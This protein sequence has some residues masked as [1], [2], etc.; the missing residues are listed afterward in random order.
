MQARPLGH[1]ENHGGGTECG[2]AVSLSQAGNLRTGDT[3]PIKCLSVGKTNKRKFISYLLNQVVNE[4]FP[5]WFPKI[6]NDV[7]TTNS[8]NSFPLH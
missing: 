8:E 7:Y 4:L 6:L 2:P 1:V 3:S 5:I